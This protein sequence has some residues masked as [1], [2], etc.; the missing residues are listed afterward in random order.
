MF[1]LFKK[2]KESDICISVDWVKKEQ[3]SAA[4]PLC[5]PHMESIYLIIGSNGKCFGNTFNAPIFSKFSFLLKGL[6]WVENMSIPIKFP[7]Y[8][9][10]SKRHSSFPS[11]CVEILFPNGRRSGVHMFL[12]DIGRMMQVDAS[13]F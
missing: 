9:R 6:H 1:D 12:E 4:L 3:C 11:N 10:D 7:F 5:C 13:T 2:G 8:G